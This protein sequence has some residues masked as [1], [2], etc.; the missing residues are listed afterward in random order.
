MQK[1]NQSVSQPNQDAGALELG[2]QTSVKSV[3]EIPSISSSFAEA[4]GQ[5]TPRIKLTRKIDTGISNVSAKWAELEKLLGKQNEELSNYEKQINDTQVRQDVKDFLIPEYNSLL[6]N[7]K[8]VQSEYEKVKSS[9]IKLQQAKATLGKIDDVQKTLEAKKAGLGENLYESFKRGSA[10]LGA[11]M[12]RTPEFIYDIAAIPQNALAEYAPET[13]GKLSVSH[14]GFANTVGLPDNK[15]AEF[16]EAAVKES[17]EKI[18]LKY[19]K[20]VSEYFADG[21]IENGFKLLANQVAESAPVSL[22]LL[23]GGLAGLG[24]KAITFGGGAVFGA[25]KKKELDEL[26]PSMGE[27]T[28]TLNALSTGLMEGVFEQYGIT[29]LG[30]VIKNIFEKE[31]KD[32]ATQVAK[33]GF[34]EVYAPTLKKYAG[35]AGEEMTGEMATQFATNVIDKYSGAKPDINLMDGVIDAGIV[36]LGASTTFSVPVSIL[37]LAKSKNRKDIYKQALKV[38]ESEKEGLVVTDMLKDGVENGSVT[39]TEADNLETD[40]NKVVQFDGLIPPTIIDTDKRMSAVNLLSERD[41]LTQENAKLESDMQGYDE[42]MRAPQQELIAKKTERINAINLELKEIGKEE[43]KPIENLVEQIVPKVE[44]LAVPKV[45][46]IAEAP[47]VVGSGVGGGVK[48]TADKSVPFTYKLVEAESLQPSHLASGERNP[49]HQIASAQPKERNDAG[50]RIAQD[51]IALKPN[52]KEVGESPNAYF[53]APIVNARGEVIQ[54]NNRSIGLKKH[55]NNNG[56]QYKSDLAA[57]AEQFGL[58]KEQVEGMK[59]PVLVREV[60]VDDATAI[61]LGQHDVKDLETGGKQSI[62]PIATSRKISPQDKGKLAALLFVDKPIKEAIREKIGLVGEIL[63]KYLNPAQIKNSFNLDGSPTAKGMDGIK[64][65]VTHFLFEG[66]DAVLPEV[67]DGLSDNVRKGIEKALPHILSIDVKNSLLPELQKAF[68]ALHEFKNGSEAKFNQWVNNVDIFKGKAPKDIFTPLELRLAK[69]LE[70]AKNQ[71][72]I[73]K[74]FK[75]HEENVQGKEANLIDEKIEGISKEE[76]IKKQFNIDNNGK[77]K[78]KPEGHA[79][80]PSKKG[81]NEPIPKKETPKGDEPQKLI[82]PEIPEPKVEA[83]TPTEAKIELIDQEFENIINQLPDNA[84]QEPLQKNLF[85]PQAEYGS[86]KEITINKEKLLV[87][88]LPEG[89]EAVNGFYS[90]SE[91]ALSQI[92]QEKM[93]GNL[94]KT[95]LLSTGAKGEEMK[96]TGLSDYLEANKDKA[97]SKIDIQQFLKDNRV[98]IVEVVKGGGQDH[99]RRLKEI[100]DELT[101]KGYSLETDMGGEGIMLLDKEGEL[102]EYDEI[103]SDILSIYQEYTEKSDSGFNP[104]STVI[105]KFEQYQL[106][107]DKS[108]YKEVLVMIP[109]KGQSLID[110]HNAIVRRRG[111]IEA[112]TGLKMPTE[113]QRNEH[114]KLGGRLQD[115]RS[116][117]P[118]TVEIRNSGIAEVPTK[119]KSSH[120]DEPNILVHL[121][122]N[123]RVDAEG[124]KVLFLEEVQSDWGQKGKKEGFKPLFKIK[125]E[126][127]KFNIYSSVNIMKGPAFSFETIK[128]AESMLSTLSSVNSNKAPS[129]PFVTD[130][131]AWTKLGLKVALKEAVKQGAEKIA[132][133]TGEQQNDRY[134]LSKTVGE[135]QYSKNEDGTYDVSATGLASGDVL[136][137]KDGMSLKDIENT[138][139]KDIAEKINNNIGDKNGSDLKGKQLMSIS[140]GGLKVGGAG[141]KGFYG[142]PTEGSLG[143]VGNVAKSLFKQEP[144]TVELSK[145]E[146]K[147]RKAEWGDGVYELVDNNGKVLETYGDKDAALEITGTSTQH[148]IDITLEMKA[149][150]EKGQALFEPNPEYSTSQKISELDKRISQV[151]KAREAKAKEL[152]KRIKEESQGDMFGKPQDAQFQIELEADVSKENFK[153]QLSIFDNEIEALKRQKE[154]LLKQQR[155]EKELEKNQTSLFEPGQEKINFPEETGE[156]SGEVVRFKRNPTNVSGLKKL[157]KNVIS[158]IESKYNAFKQINLYARNTKIESVDDAAFIFRALETQKSENFFVIHV[159]EDGSFVAQHLSTGSHNQTVAGALS[160][161][162]GIKRFKTKQLYTV[163]NH[164]S[165]SLKASGADFS[166][167][168]NFKKA[169]PTGVELMPSI[170]IN[171][172][173]GKY[174]IF[175]GENISGEM[176]KTEQI[177]DVPTGDKKFKVKPLAFSRQVLHQPSSNWGKISSSK[178]AAEYLSN[179]KRGVDKTQV[180]VMNNNHMITGVFFSKGKTPK[181]IADEIG[182]F[183]SGQNANNVI[184]S[185]S[186]EISRKDLNEL[187]GNL[188]AKEIKLLDHIIVRSENGIIKN[189]ESLGDE[190]RL[191]ESPS[192]YKGSGKPKSESEINKTKYAIKKLSEKYSEE[193]IKDMLSR[194]GYSESEIKDVFFSTQKGKKDLSG[195]E[196]K[197]TVVTIRAYEGAFR[198]GVKKELEKL[199]LTREIENQAEAEA[200]GK[201][202]VEKVGEETALQAVRNNDIEGGMAAVVWNDL[203]ERVEKKLA[204]EKDPQKI[205]ELEAMEAQLLN[206]WGKQSLSSGRFNAMHNRIYQTSDLGYNLQNKIKNFKDQ[207]NGEIPAEVEAKFRAIDAELKDVR[208]KLIEAEEKTKKATEKSEELQAIIDIKESVERDKKQQITSAKIK[209]ATDRLVAKV[210]EGKL[211]RPNAFSAA[212][213]GSIVWD[214]ALEVVAKTVKATGKVAEAVA[215]GMEHIA[216]SEWYKNLTADKQS[217]A[218][219]AYKDYFIDKE[220]V[221]EGKIKIPHSVIRDLVESGV[222]NI[223]DLVNELRAT[224]PEELADK[225]DREIRD[226]VTNYGKRI[227]MNKEQ[228]EVDIRKMKRIG[229][230]I[231][232][233]EDVQNKKRPL[234]SGLQRDKLDANERAMQKELRELMKELPVDEEL[235]AEQQK[236]ATD[237]AKQ[238]LRN[239][240]EDLQREI[241]KGEKIIKSARTV[242]DDAELKDLKEQRDK[243]KQEYDEKFKDD[244]FKE[245]K[246]LEQTKKRTEQR[247]EYLQK[248]IQTS[249][250]SKK[251]VKPLIADT[252]LTKLRAEKIRLQDEYD[253]EFFKYKLINRTKG[254]KIKNGIWEAWGLTR[255]VSATGEFSFVGVQGLIQSVAHPTYAKEAFKTAMRSFSSESK[256]QQ[257]LNN[258]K[259]QE[260]YPELKQSKLALTEVHAEIKAREELYV[261]DYANMIWNVLGFP[262]K[263]KSKTAFEKW[264]SASPFSAFERAAVGYLDTLRVMR[265]LDGKKMLEENGISFAKNPEAY[266]QMANAINTMTGRASLGA[267]EQIAPALTKIFFSPRNWASLL[268][269]ATPYA[270]YHFGKM[271]SGAE[272]FKPSVAQKMAISDFSK[273]LGLTISMMALATAYFN[274]DDDEE[275][276]VEFDPTSSDFGKIKIGDTRVDP[277]GGRIQQ[278][279][280][281]SRFI[282]E[283]IKDGQGETIPLGVPFKTPTRKDLLIEMATNKLA[284]SASMIEKYLS[285][286]VDEQDDR[287]TKY[288][289]PYEFSEELKEK[290]HP[291]YW[292]TVNDLL[293]DDKT[294]L[295]GLLLFYAFFGGGVNVYEK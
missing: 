250:F 230:L 55:Y 148:S 74:I 264:K 208:A 64:E 213:P 110:E 5:E 52:F 124:N 171:L 234:R 260:W 24:P 49:E 293:K 139:G 1:K 273:Y 245:K 194:K 104:A 57:N 37:D 45:E 195:G 179:Q 135:I 261:S 36:G 270:F 93:S 223:N 218:E 18:A 44:A 28:K 125:K 109:N 120:F 185:S 161:L 113:S 203:V 132:W 67:Y 286:R 118:S 154:E 66:G 108:N 165:G 256:T 274:N 72:D 3:S 222:D 188:K 7:S 269:T 181:A 157:A 282:S 258:I 79:E 277:W 47:K 19:D 17:Q 11:M 237:T 4:V 231:S 60:K 225:T 117:F 229:K 70:S 73:Q 26:N 142:S 50:S 259:A 251:V 127:G 77:E 244:E 33:K 199:G 27:S 164:P 255:L 81:G 295:D 192:E 253:K 278:V 13:F 211:Q 106:E 69:E 100:E 56:T 232:A 102:M 288:G 39:Q 224:L 94:W 242:K 134:D 170:I 235:Q 78:N 82:T 285:S 210:R 31:G 217:K 263:L 145:K 271:R 173:S 238:R 130:T 160:I 75:Q 133:T 96:W 198:E 111:E 196:T 281:L 9:A 167:H 85:E 200:K 226:A 265:F 68:L 239:Q 95:K 247:I 41:N 292:G 35:I 112:E 294:A 8:K 290:L 187:I 275:T 88:P 21:Q 32:I 59:N 204:T 90:N 136:M 62:D 105:G 138:L 254:E 71:A 252:E 262:L 119:F 228:I 92:K 121:R 54:G 257:W 23:V 183:A 289:Q 97:I 91:N 163:H 158:N 197:K 151:A 243:K 86:P 215:K 115:I 184:I 2:D 14:Q 89:V 241:D 101:K 10:S 146:G 240:I 236:T 207:N 76:S 98:S 159:R 103:P 166:V 189:Y 150:A 80:L 149:E 233:I 156:G 280:L 15:V 267:A 190:N 169:L 65:T 201:E 51:A 84:K 206:E 40:I 178:D 42:T 266:K 216:A 177:R 168:S 34:M 291:I 212:T 114:N 107:G 123:T 172:D 20:S 214:G 191:E 155:N 129:A 279:V 283:S 220:E 63:R 6:E 180:I 61:K 186:K 268:K 246:R 176:S 43:I 221:T 175:E 48:F 29:K 12:A 248:R 22:S 205:M 83:K 128:E 287:V 182:E 25:A 141:M 284:P 16:Y 147:L 162:D 58:T 122:M 227:N 38:K 174:V 272:G 140:G 137:G 152:S 126:N 144:K 53:G 276:S 219:K 202:F 30:G 116:K 153:K 249:D 143:I 99:S 46:P 193:E 87:K 209:Q 131:N